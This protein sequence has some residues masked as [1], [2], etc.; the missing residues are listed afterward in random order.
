M[1]SCWENGK[2]IN[3]F[4]IIYFSLH[5]VN[6]VKLSLWCSLRRVWLSKNKQTKPQTMK[7]NTWWLLVLTSYSTNIDASLK[8]IRFSH[9]S[10]QVTNCFMA[11]I[12]LNYCDFYSKSF[13]CSTPPFFFLFLLTSNNNIAVILDMFMMMIISCAFFVTFEISVSLPL[14]PQ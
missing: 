14:K 3:H 6:V 2:E 11:K 4:Y 12:Y 7:L 8:E 10:G 1:K 5:I 9:T 13:V